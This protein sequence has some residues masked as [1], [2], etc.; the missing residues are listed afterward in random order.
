[1]MSGIS[2][3]LQVIILW[4]KFQE[5]DFSYMVRVNVKTILNVK[6]TR[7]NYSWSSVRQKQH[8]V[9]YRKMQ[10]ILK[11]EHSNAEAANELVNFGAVTSTRRIQEH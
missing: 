2:I 5:P 4:L 3:T 7:L 10:S 6:E 1:M 9:T 11:G 8:N